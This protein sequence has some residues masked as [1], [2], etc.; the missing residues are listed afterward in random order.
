MSTDPREALGIARRAARAGA[1]T[2]SEYWQR[3]TLDQRFKPDGSRVTEA[4]LATEATVR[5]VLS[6]L[7]PGEAV[8]A[9]ESGGADSPAHRWIV[10]PI[11]GTE[12]FSRGNPVWAV[13][14]ARQVG[15]RVDVAVIDAPSLHQT[16]WA[17]SGGGAFSATR[18]RLRVS[19]RQTTEGGTFCYG[20]LHEC[21]SSTA[22]Q[23]V[24]EL[25]GRFRCAWGWGNFWGAVQ[26]AEG[27]A[28]ASL[29]YG[30]EIWDVAATSLLVAEAGGRWTD[31][32]GHLSLTSGS[33]VSSNGHLHD[34]VI[35]ELAGTAA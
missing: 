23:R 18:G 10:D 13:L 5:S 15:G 26:V 25:A 35:A 28:E 29:S 20:G 11:D 9:E 24:E 22:R 8:I 7:A 34:V 21:P 19:E 32:D 31:V 16:W 30:T 1:R 27:A 2:A 4:D 17:C 3:S 14:V 12:N 6:E 33:F